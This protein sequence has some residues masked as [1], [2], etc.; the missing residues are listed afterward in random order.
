MQQ[1]HPIHLIVLI[2]YF[3]VI[4]LLS[5]FASRRVKGSEDMLVSGRNMGL[6]FVA[7]SV[8]AEY[9]GGL[10]TIGCAERAFTEGMGVIWY[11][12]AAAIGLLIF[13]LFFSHYYRKYG[14]QTIPEYFY[15]LYDIKTWKA[16]AVLNV[17]AYTFFTLIQIA[18]LG[19]IIAGVTGLPLKWMALA[20]GIFITSYVFVAGM[21]SLAYTSILYMVTIYIS[22]PLAFWWTLRY[23]VPH[24]A[25]S[26]GVAGFAGMVNVMVARGMDPSFWF[27]PFSLGAAG[28]LGFLIGGILAVPASQATVNYAFGAKNWK[29]AR[30]A[31]LLAAIL[32]LPISIWTGSLGIF[33]RLA[34]LVTE[35]K[36]S[37]PGTLAYINPWV[38]ALGIAGIF[39]A[40]ISTAAGVLFA[41]S[42]VFAKDIINRWLSPKAN[43]KQVLKWVKLS[44]LIIGVLC[45]LGAM[46]LPKILHQA[47]F[48][49][50]LRS[51]AFIA[52]I[53]G[54]YW[55]KA[56]PDAA[57]W[58]IITGTIAAIM[59]N[60]SGL[61]NVLHLH[62]AIF[63]VIIALP[64]FI[65]L[66]LVRKWTP[67][68]SLEL[69]P[70]YKEM[71]E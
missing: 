17:I 70:I 49:Y 20:G 58:S 37:L 8:A 34:G 4:I 1:F 31:P 66:S 26:G 29:I 24:L 52:I 22:L 5:C 27:S 13:G 51:C 61:S 14:I 3:L 44:T 25:D 18:A 19:S 23:E 50:S 15:Y 9:I 6:F 32:V 36:L 71:K 40:V 57:F 63:T 55:K 2:G 11:H 10:G 64:V 7:C 30:L 12:I 53:F 69:P 65:I 60:F 68:T 16:N 59:Y 33:A 47:Y 42:S 45:S 54:I 38:G 56:H 46:T 43:D 35:P 41:S 48:V 21:W 39:A 67:Q 62:V 28:T